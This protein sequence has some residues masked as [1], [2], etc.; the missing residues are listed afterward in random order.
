MTARKQRGRESF[1]DRIA[2][3]FG[4]RPAMPRRPRLA[5]GARADKIGVG[6][7]NQTLLGAGRACL[8]V[9]RSSLVSRRSQA[10]IFLACEIR[11]TLHERRSFV[12]RDLGESTGFLLA[13]VLRIG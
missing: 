13:A 7:C 2:T 6:S 11:F 4:R 8:T 5:A 12:E 3:G 9:R 1:L 10:V